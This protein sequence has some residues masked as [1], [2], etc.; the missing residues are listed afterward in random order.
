LPDGA[1]YQGQ[2][3]NGKANGVGTEIRADGTTLQGQFKDGNLNGLGE[4]RLPSDAMSAGRMADGALIAGADQRADGTVAAGFRWNE[5]NRMVGK[6]EFTDTDG[7]SQIGYFDKD[8]KQLALGPESKPGEEPVAP[9]APQGMP[10]EDDSDVPLWSPT[11]PAGS[12]ISYEMEWVPGSAI[13]WASLLPDI[14]GDPLADARFCRPLV[15]KLTAAQAKACQEDKKDVKAAVEKDPIGNAMFC[16]PLLGSLTAEEKAACGI[17]DE[18][19]PQA[20]GCISGGA[21]AMMGGF[22]GLLASANAAGSGACTT[23]AGPQRPLTL[24]ER[25]TLRM[26]G[27]MP[28][29]TAMAAPQPASAPPADNAIYWPYT[30]AQ[31][32]QLYPRYRQACDA[33]IRAYYTVAVPEETHRTEFLRDH[34][35][36]IAREEIQQEYN[37]ISGYS[38][39]VGG[40]DAAYNMILCADGFLLNTVRSR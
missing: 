11:T 6:V 36:G 38:A 5:G 39:Q 8:G 31:L 23:I 33:Q 15:G 29:R 26:T 13:P 20:T 9:P 1:I 37:R 3:K 34:Y 32:D 28:D 22:G 12:I 24:E 25:K 35:A 21:A 16:R 10:E 18:P 17:K 19:A 40:R 2:T 30:R 27:K 7:S 14:P 4:Y